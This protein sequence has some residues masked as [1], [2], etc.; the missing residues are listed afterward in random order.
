MPNTDE[1]ALSDEVEQL[2]NATKL[3]G[4]ALAQLDKI[5]AVS[6]LE[7]PA[8]MAKA[9]Y[10]SALLELSKIIATL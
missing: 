4:T 2:V 8:N 3:I 6:P 7:G 5:L 9:D 10:R 1:Q